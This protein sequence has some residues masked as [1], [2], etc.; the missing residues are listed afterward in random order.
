MTLDSNTP[1]LLETIRDSK[2]NQPRRDRTER[3]QAAMNGD[4]EEETETVLASHSSV[5]K[6]AHKLS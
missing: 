4:I 2:K 3:R 6:L 1:P 5:S